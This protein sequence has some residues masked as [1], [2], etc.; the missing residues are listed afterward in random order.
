VRRSRDWKSSGYDH[1]PRTGYRS[2]CNRDAETRSNLKHS[3]TLLCRTPPMQWERRRCFSG[4]IN[5]SSTLK[6]PDEKTIN[7]LASSIFSAQE[8][9]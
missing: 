9:I 7:R 6:P 4:K 3:K 2:L 5:L 8:K 1:Y